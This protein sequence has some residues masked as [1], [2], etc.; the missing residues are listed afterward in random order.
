M[1]MCMMSAGLVSVCGRV[2]RQ[3]RLQHRDGIEAKTSQYHARTG[4]RLGKYVMINSVIVE[5][6]YIDRYTVFECLYRI[7]VVD[8]YSVRG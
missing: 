8:F 4:I 6:D 7:F 3:A 2:R 5:I 1:C